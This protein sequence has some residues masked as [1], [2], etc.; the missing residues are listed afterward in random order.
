MQQLGCRCNIW[1]LHSHQED[2]ESRLI[3]WQ[4]VRRVLITTLVLYYANGI[5][6]QLTVKKPNNSK[7]MGLY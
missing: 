1:M 7:C 4:L 3:G 5:A 6:S 2:I